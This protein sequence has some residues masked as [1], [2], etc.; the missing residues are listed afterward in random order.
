MTRARIAVLSAA[1]LALTGL[2]GL[3]FAG[4]RPASAQDSKPKPAEVGK[5]A[6]DFTLTD[7]SGK[8]VKLSSFKDKIVVLEWFNPDCPVV[9]RQ[10]DAA[11]LKTLAADCTKLGVVWLAINSAAPGKQG[12]DKE[13]NVKAAEAWG[14]THPILLDDKG[15]V[16][17]QY[18][19]TNTPQMFVIDAKG[20]LAYAGAIDNDEKGEVEPA[21]RV[22]YP[23]VAIE[24]LQK[25][26]KV[27]TPTTKAYGCS[28]KYAD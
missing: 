5:P 10:H 14:L 9:K 20:V 12:A 2:S 23:L 1:V 28:V 27:K 16:G 6:P 19:A 11:A 13:R 26:E 21:K 4:A 8:E 22:I 18:G 3:A 25:G 15:T 24:A 17:R 7:T